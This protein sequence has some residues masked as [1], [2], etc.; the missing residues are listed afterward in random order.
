MNKKSIVMSYQVYDFTND[1]GDQVSGVSIYLLSDELTGENQGGYRVGKFNIDLKTLQK[2]KSVP[3]V[4]DAHF[5]MRVNAKNE[6]SIVLKDINFVK[7]FGID[8]N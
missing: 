5:D 4:V 8:L 1:N 7:P 2:L 3:C 6:P